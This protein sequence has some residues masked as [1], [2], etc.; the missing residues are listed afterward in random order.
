MSKKKKTSATSKKLPKKKLVEMPIADLKPHPL[1]AE[2]FANLSDADTDA[3]KDDIAENGLQNPIEILS[4]GTVVCGHQRLRA[5]ERLGWTHVTC[6]MREDLEKRGAYAV[7]QRLLD[8]N[9]HRRQLSPFGYARC[10]LQKIRLVHGSDYDHDEVARELRNRIVE[11]FN[12]SAK[13][14]DRIVKMLQAPIAVQNAHESNE[15]TQKDV[16]GV[17][18][19]NE[20]ERLAISRQIEAGTP[21]KSAIAPYVGSNGP[22]PVSA[23]AVLRRL[24]KSLVESERQLA[25]RMD[26]FPGERL[27]Y[28]LPIFLGGCEFLERVYDALREQIETERLEREEEEDIDY[29]F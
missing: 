22:R 25:N 8:D 29:G 4:V 2:A 6:W 1:Q 18:E 5:C 11:K 27:S 20:E 16:L 17:V 28:C 13:Q 12:L 23:A 3:L 26:E 21:P 24:A 19:L 14:A 7:I 10:F 15:L 9:S